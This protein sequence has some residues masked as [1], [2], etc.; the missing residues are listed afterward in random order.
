MCGR[1]YIESDDIAEELQAIIEEV[2]RKQKEREEKE[3]T[4][5]APSLAVKQGEVYPSDMAAVVT[6]DHPHAMR[7]GFT[8]F[9]GKGLVINAR[10]ETIGEKPMFR[11][12]RPCLVPASHYFEWE[13][14]GKE[15]VKYRIGLPGKPIYMAGLY[16]MEQ[17][18]PVFTILTRDP[19]P[20]IAFIHD[21]MPL[22]L[23]ASARAA[24]LN[25]DMTN[26][27]LSTAELSVVFEQDGGQLSFA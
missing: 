24:W 3:Q 5:P 15:K 14:R 20:Q 1:Y 6:A 8:R 2:N 12:A 7:W 27:V 16:R 26:D 22:I 11:A 17:G 25:G 10:S 13:H 4:A 9:D 19:A 18:A 23:P 21:R